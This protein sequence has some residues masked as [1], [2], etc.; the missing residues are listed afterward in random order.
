MQIDD[1]SSERHA[2]AEAFSPN[3]RR[4]G[5]GPMAKKGADGLAAPRMRVVVSMQD[6][7]GT[8][9]SH[10]LEWKQDGIRDTA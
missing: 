3:A 2:E 7:F 10:L 9:L 1:K 4:F 5:D 8:S 6:G